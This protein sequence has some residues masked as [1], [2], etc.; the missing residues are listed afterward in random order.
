MS[1]SR[2]WFFICKRKTMTKKRITWLEATRVRAL[3]TVAQTAITTK[4]SSR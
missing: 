1:Q 3:K 2:D 4:Y